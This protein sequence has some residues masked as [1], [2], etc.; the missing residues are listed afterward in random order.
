[1]PKENEINVFK[2]TVRY[3]DKLED[4][5]RSNLSRRPILY[6]LIGGVAIVLFWRGV[7]MTADKF[8]FMTGPVSIVISVIILLM[9]GLFASFF[10]GDQ[11]VISGLKRDKKIIDKTEEEIKEELTTLTE[12]K[13]A[14]KEIEHKLE[15]V[16]GDVHKNNPPHES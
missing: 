6:S 15:R 4:K 7:W 8:A 3:F 9:T 12:V 5:V 11:I 1:M 10:V 14:L 2:R 13:R 16:E